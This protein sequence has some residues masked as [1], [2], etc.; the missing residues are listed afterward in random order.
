MQ[1]LSPAPVVL[2][3]S[4]SDSHNTRVH[5]LLVPHENPRFVSMLHQ[6]GTSPSLVPQILNICML[7]KDSSSKDS[8]KHRSS[9]ILVGTVI[10][11]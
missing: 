10:G 11:K 4:P 7:N 8:V 9:F 6:L 2:A 1:I 5:N 3:R